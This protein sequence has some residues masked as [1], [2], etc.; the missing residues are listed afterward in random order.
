[1]A[2]LEDKDMSSPQ[3][4]ASSL[5]KILPVSLPKA[6]RTAAAVLK[7][8]HVI[9]TPTDTIYGIAAL[10]QNNTAVQRLYEIKGRDT[11]KPI[12]LC[13]AEIDQIFDWGQV[14]VNRSLLEEL[15][16]GPV[17][18]I[19]QRKPTLNP[20][21]NPGT[22]LIGIR[23][24]DHNFVREVCRFCEG[25]VALTSANP[26][27]AKSTLSVEEFQGLHAK[28]HSVFDGGRLSDSEEAR[29]GSTVIDLSIPGAYKIIRNGSAFFRTKK[30]LESFELS[31]L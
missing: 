21:F 22:D 30:V 13:L 31:P 25:P 7:S 20:E 5:S 9:A 16:P 12:A 6:S 4:I 27:S 18:I 23:I 24:P 19:F 1:M 14:T 10:V 11:L 2:R 28:L 17:T 26:S 8:G 3:I 29:L 15:L